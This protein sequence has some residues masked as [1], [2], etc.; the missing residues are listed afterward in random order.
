MF[1]VSLSV[2]CLHLAIEVIPVALLSLHAGL[3]LSEL[4]LTSQ[5]LLSLLVDLTLHLDL[6]LSQ[7]LF[8]TSELFFLEANGLVGE[9]FRIDR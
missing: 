2:L 5:Q 1:Q 8:F 3:D 6:N 4:T 7:L 9:V